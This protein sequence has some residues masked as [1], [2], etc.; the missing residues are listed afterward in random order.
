MDLLEDSIINGSELAVNALSHRT[1]SRCT[2]IAC[3][4]Q[5]AD[6]K[7]KVFEDCFFQKCD[8][9]LAQVVHTSF[10]K[11]RFEHSKLLGLRF[12]QCHA[13]LL[14]VS[15]QHTVLDLANFH[16]LRLKKTVFDT[17]RL[18]ET[19]LAAADLSGAIFKNCDLGA[20]VFDRTVLEGADLRTA[21]HYTIDPANNRMRKARFSREGLDG[22]LSSTGILIEN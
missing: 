5:Q 1:Y 9:S 12:D 8:L 16:G 6:L 10:R 2:F 13:F 20:A 17:C 22:L 11:V 19:D 21:Q 7:G 14:E 18:R 4:L 3:N 15:F